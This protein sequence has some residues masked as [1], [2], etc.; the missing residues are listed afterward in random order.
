MLIGARVLHSLSAVAVMSING[1]LFGLFIHSVFSAGMAIN[2]LM[3]AMSTA[4]GSTVATGV[5]TVSC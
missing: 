5:L 4:A 2:M 3:I 1:R